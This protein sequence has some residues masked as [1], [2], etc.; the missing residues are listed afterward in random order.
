MKWWL[1]ALCAVLLTVGC[2]PATPTPLAPPT[3]KVTRLAPEQPGTETSTPAVLPSAT[4]VA[5][6]AE[7][8]ATAVQT[9]TPAV[10]S[11]PLATPKP[12][13]TF[14]PTSA[15]QPP[16][17]AT[18]TL[19]FT[20]TSAPKQ[21]PSATPTAA[22]VEKWQVRTLLAGPGQPGRLYVLLTDEPSGAWPAQ[23]ARFLISDDDGKSW[24]PFP[25][26]LPAGGCVRNVNLDYATPDALYASTCQGL[27]RWSGS[28][29]V[30][31]SPQETGMVA[32]VYGTPQIIWATVPF[33]SGGAVIRSDDGGATWTPASSSLVH[34]NGVANLGI[35]PRDANTLYAVIWPKYA[36]SYLRRGAANGQWQTMPTPLNNAQIDTGMTID[37]ATGALYVTAYSPAGTWELWR[38]LNPSVPD[39]N[40]VQWELVYDFGGDAAWAT[41]LA[42]GWSPQGLALY[43]LLTP[44]L[45]KPSGLVGD[46]VLHRSVDGGQ[47]WSPLPVP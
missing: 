9:S 45:D 3:E 46:P 19:P 10:P 17:T 22:A 33:A 1:M 2:G 12:S 21:T 27:Y 31:I 11:Q 35:D 15:P 28:A 6:A 13:P 42:S 39:V 20:P 47:T 30:L 38:T 7:L 32:V 40:G 24:S 5:T 41:L 44:W 29:W 14:T 43:A 25:G 8:E 4:G 37:G 26:G 23:R 16:A 18:P 34:F 36:G